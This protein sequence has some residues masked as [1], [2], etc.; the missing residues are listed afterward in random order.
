MNI[1]A[2]TTNAFIPIVISQRDPRAPKRHDTID[3]PTKNQK[4]SISDRV[5]IED[6]AESV[7]VEAEPPAIQFGERSDLR[8]A[9]LGIIRPDTRQ[10]GFVDGT[11]LGFL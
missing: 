7:F 3:V 6:C 10:V 2:D 8:F 1:V 11:M 9:R 4:R 5:F